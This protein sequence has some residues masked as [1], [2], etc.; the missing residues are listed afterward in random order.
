M[1]A[2]ERAKDILARVRHALRAR[3]FILVASGVGFAALGTAHL[4][5]L[6]N[7]NVPLWLY[8]AFAAVPFC[9][10]VWPL[11]MERRLF[12]AGRRM[13]LG[14]R[15]AGLSAALQRRAN[16]FLNPLL[17]ELRV[18]LRRL[19][20][21]EVLAFVPPL[22]LG[23]LLLLVPAPA[24]PSLTVVEIS[25]EELVPAE[26]PAEEEEKRLTVKEEEKT[27]P[28]EIPQLPPGF[29]GPSPYSQLLSALLGE[30]LSLEEAVERLA[31][32]EGLLR[33]IWESLQE[34]KASGLT[35]QKAAEIGDIV[36]ELTRPDVREALSQNLARG[37]EGLAEAEEVVAA[38][39]EGLARLHEEALAPGSAGESEASIE[40]EASG[41]FS[42]ETPE[43]WGEILPD[44]VLGAPPG[45]AR[46]GEREEA[47][48][49]LGVGTEEGERG[50]EAT[51]LAW[52]GESQVVSAE[53]RP[54]EGPVRTGIQLFLPGE[55]AAADGEAP[56]PLTPQQV[57]LWLRE[58]NLPPELRDLVRRYF[59]LLAG[60]G[61]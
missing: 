36:E 2:A 52:E 34:A 1:V 61:S 48:E 23:I 32:E 9:S 56:A 28:P 50:T 58:A 49:G 26:A 46:R 20:F 33:R 16:A 38:A 10:L 4:A 22:L 44:V 29:A 5:H 15:L 35:P 51:P 7:W 55:S 39:L 11:S 13:G 45:E 3:R 12:W 59:E 17:H 53:V 24:P 31:Q 8:L 14:G 27:G 41:E 60:G 57:E 40:G 37:E 42:F 25:S 21:P 19:L 18:P 43:W 30:E 54:G 6:L 47:Q